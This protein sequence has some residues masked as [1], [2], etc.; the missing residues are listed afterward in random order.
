M[1][2]DVMDKH[3]IAHPKCIFCGTTD[4]SQF[5]TK[6]HII[7]ESLIGG[8]F[9][10]LPD[11]FYCDSCQNI[12]GSTI[13]QQ[14]LGDYPFINFRVLFSVPTKKKKAPWMKTIVGKMYAGGNIGLIGLDENDSTK[15]SEFKHIM[16]PS[17]SKKPDMILRLLLKIG[18]EVIAASQCPEMV[19]DQRYNAARHYALTGEKSS[20]WF[21]IIN[22]DMDTFNKYIQSGQITIEEWKSNINT[23]IKYEDIG[24][25][26]LYLKIIY[27]DFIVP[28]TENVLPNDELIQECI[29]REP[30]TSLV[31]I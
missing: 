5:T 7:P 11:G 19:Y 16:L 24:V 28:L 8:T 2:G 21:Y 17:S 10:L 6:E 30:F 25:E 4:S 14:A 26:V 20:K 27:L 1:T 22:H 12:F 23:Y 15:K 31:Y 29:D 13:E 9:A 18:I 3:R